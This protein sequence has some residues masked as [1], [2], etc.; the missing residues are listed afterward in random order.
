MLAEALA[1]LSRKELQKRAKAEGV[2]ANQK[3]EFII[4][5]LLALAPKPESATALELCSPIEKLLEAVEPIDESPASRRRSKRLSVAEPVEEPAEQEAPAAAPA[6]EAASSEPE[7]DA[8]PPKRPAFKAAKSSKHAVIAELQQ[9]LQN[10]A[11]AASPEPTPT[12]A[13][14]VEEPPASRRRSK[15][16]SA[17][18]Q[19]QPA[20][21]P[22]PEP[23]AEPAAEA[24]PVAEPVAKTQPA[25]TIAPAVVAAP[26]APMP[27][28][29]PETKESAGPS[30]KRPATAPAGKGKENARQLKPWERPVWRP[31]KSARPLTKPKSH[32][33][34]AAPPSGVSAPGSN[35]ASLKAAQRAKAVA[36]D[37]KAKQEAR[38]EAARARQSVFQEARKI[39]APPAVSGRPVAAWDRPASAR[40]AS[41]KMTKR[42][43]EAS[44]AAPKPFKARPLNPKVMASG[45]AA[46]CL[47][48]PRIAGKKPTQAKA[49]RFT[50]DARNPPRAAVKPKP[51]AIGAS[52]TP[53]RKAKAIAQRPECGSAARA[54]ALA[55]ARGIEASPVPTPRGG[56]WC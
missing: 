36:A 5:E 15:R 1:S 9:R 33:N 40:P 46:G 27:A 44:K 10:M 50:T 52:L 4:A 49:F 42:P 17:I 54:Q 23:V 2:R 41:A 28:A 55:E 25:P 16:L 8:P 7:M 26:A 19:Q 3:S 56:V 39:N 37:Q 6:V 11:P 35:L 18:A 13:E 20:S 30:Q 45:A 24:A 29:A 32:F 21:E 43:V 47:G 14:T 31:Q 51:A 34:A 38:R 22:A 48:V 53:K 12:A